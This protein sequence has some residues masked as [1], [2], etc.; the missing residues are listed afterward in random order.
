MCVLE[1]N[2]GAE[3]DSSGFRDLEL[4]FEASQCLRRNEK[5]K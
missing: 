2:A 1:M 5:Q 4:I 3:D